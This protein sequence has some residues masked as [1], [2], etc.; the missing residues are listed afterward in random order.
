MDDA[1]VED[2]KVDHVDDYVNYSSTI[3]EKEL[4]IPLPI[5]QVIEEN[6]EDEDWCLVC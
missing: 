1:E 4:E 3:N 6:Y 2:E 5:E